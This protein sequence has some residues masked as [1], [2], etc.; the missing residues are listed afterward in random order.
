MVSKWEIY[1]CDLNPSVGRE[2]KGLRP[3]LVISRD[4]INHRLQTSTVVTLS[5]MKKDSKTYPSEVLLKME[6]TGLPK[7]SIAMMQQVRTLSHIRFINKVG[8][9]ADENLRNQIEKTICDYFE[10]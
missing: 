5:S 6:Y 9:L 10:V 2:Q 4:S 7:D 8:T 3:V 1:F